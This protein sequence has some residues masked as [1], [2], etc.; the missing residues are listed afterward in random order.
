MLCGASRRNMGVQPLLDA[1]VDYLPAPH[2]VPPARAHD[3]KK[4]EDVELPCDEA[5]YPMGLVFKVQNDREMGPLCYVR[6]YSGVI[7]AAGTIYNV[8]K[9]KRERVTPFRSS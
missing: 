2:D 6:M 7:K 8:A 5:G 4:D 1:V 9:K 3:P